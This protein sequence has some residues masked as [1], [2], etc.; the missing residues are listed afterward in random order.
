MPNPSDLNFDMLLEYISRGHAFPK[1]VEG[2]DPGSIMEGKNA[3]KDVSYVTASG[4]NAELPSLHINTPEDLKGYM[5]RMIDSPDTKGF[6][7]GSDREMIHLF[8]TKDNTYMIVNAKDADFGTIFRYPTSKEQFRLKGIEEQ[9]DC[10]KFATFDNAVDRNAARTHIQGLIDRTSKYTRVYALDKEPGI[11]VAENPKYHGSNNLSRTGNSDEFIAFAKKMDDFTA[12]RSGLDYGTGF[13][14]ELDD[15]GRPHHMFFLDKETST[16]TEIKGRK[17]TVHNFDNIAESER[18]ATAEQFF[19]MNNIHGKEA[20]DGGYDALVKDFLSQHKG[21]MPVAGPNKD[22]V[23]TGIDSGNI[24]VVNNSPY[25]SIDHA[26]NRFIGF[27]DD[28]ANIFNKIPD[29]IPADALAKIENENVISAL[30]DLSAAKSFTKVE[31][32]KEAVDALKLFSET[33]DQMDAPTRAAVISALETLEKVPNTG[34]KAAKLAGTALEGLEELSDLAKL[35]KTLKAGRL[36]MNM[37]KAGLVTTVVTTGIAVGLTSHANAAVLDIAD[38]LHAS[39]QLSDEA[40]NDY[41]EMMDSVGPMLTGQAA[42]PFITAIPGT[43]I[44]ENIAHN[45]FQ[46]F[47]DKHQLPENIHAMLTP[48][49]FA[50]TAIRGEIGENTYKTIPD[51]P[52]DAPEIMGALVTAKQ[53]VIAARENYWKV[54]E[55]NSPPLW[56]RALSGSDPA[57]AIGQEMAISRNPNVIA[58]QEEIDTAKAKFQA[59]FDRLLSTP[60]GASALAE[61]LSEDQLLEIVD[62]TAKYNTDDQSP[63]IQDYVKAQAA[64]APWY[65][66][67]G[68]WHNMRARDEATENLRKNPQVM[69][70]YLAKI[71]VKDSPL[72]ADNDNDN[73]LNNPQIIPASMSPQN[74]AVDLEG[75]ANFVNI[76]N[77]FERLKAGGDI[78]PAESAEIRNFMNNP[79][80]DDDRRLIEEITNR[81]PEQANE[82]LDTSPSEPQSAATPQKIIPE[83]SPVLESGGGNIRP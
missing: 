64:D 18:A 9:K 82:Y 16:V 28:K 39:G 12:M 62:A 46:E 3:F 69:K 40:Y 49:L 48:S 21:K 71:F 37:S 80:S 34:A 13:V 61:L 66:L 29:D 32:P 27:S 79:Q 14:A 22:R 5:Q 24:S 58:A 57:S 50:G 17:I 45:R 68:A 26:T 60:E 36:G 4:G 31:D 44:V 8:N 65:D 38:Q 51:N 54:R 74:P 41:K 77:S 63:L 76:A 81:Y 43:F 30:R 75:N 78:T 23:V 20:I 25:S 56:V 33:F 2:I 1:H 73:D 59:E 35:A 53:E 83:I 67:S 15:K 42:D 55:E 7:T 52:A 11:R 70:E 19:Y 6:I 10:P 72:P 47:S